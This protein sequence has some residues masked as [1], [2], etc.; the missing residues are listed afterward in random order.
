MRSLSLVA[1]ALVA[2]CGASEPVAVVPASPPPP[3]AA[4]ITKDAPDAASAAPVAAAADAAAPKPE[5]PKIVAFKASLGTSGDLRI[6]LEH[7]AKGVRAMIAAGGESVLVS[8]TWTADDRISLT[9]APIA[10]KS[11]VS[12]EGRIEGGKLRGEWRDPPAKPMPI[13]GDALVPDGATSKG[14]EQSYMGSLGATT[15]IRA[16]LT[17]QPGG[18]VRGVYRYPKSQ[19]DMQLL[20]KLQTSDG[21]FSFEER[22][23]SGTLTGRIDGVFLAPEF[24]FARWFSADGQKT[25]PVAL[26]GT[27]AYP[28][29]VPLGGGGGR[30]APQEDYF[31][32]GRLC[33]ITRLFPRLEGTVAGPRE[34]ALNAALKQEAGGISKEGCQI[35]EMDL[36]YEAET[37]YELT[38][39][40]ATALAFRFQ[41][42]EFAGGAHGMHGISCPV[43]DLTSGK[44][45]KLTPKLLT[46]AGRAALG[47]RVKK[48]L[49]APGGD[50]AAMGITEVKV[51]DDTTLCDDHDD[52]IVQFQVYEIGP[53][54][55]G[56]PTVKVAKVD[57]L[58]MF[59]PSPLTDAL[60]K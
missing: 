50:L 5:A 2:A 17:V 23:P 48:E 39:E 52:L 16:R 57:A 28:G 36:R 13:V 55:M 47:A 15:R 38:A 33:S 41:F 6:A 60:F 21:S 12:F 8:G 44:L 14:F 35:S 19:A 51:S 27:S 46:P 31:E 24:V 10:G 30:V 53:Y 26:R 45:V 56:A 7:D 43:A 42:Y 34:K 9:Q 40:R 58:K 54:A 4:P 3:P 29:M 32:E 20:G 37:T 49:L 22:A 25:F 18:S 59:A 11:G 1:A